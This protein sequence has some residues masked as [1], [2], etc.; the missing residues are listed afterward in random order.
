MA[1]L[2]EALRELDPE[3]DRGR[4]AGAAGAPARMMWALNRGAEAVEIAERALAMLPADDPER[5]AAAAAG[6]A[7]AQPVPARPVPRAVADGEAALETAV[8]AGDARRRGRGAQHA[9]AWPG[10]RSATSTAASSR[11]AA[12]ADR[13]ASNE[14][15]DSLATAYSN[16][17]DMLSVAGRTAEALETAREGLAATPRHHARSHD[18]MK[19]TVAEHGLRGRRL[20]AGP[21]AISPAAVA[22]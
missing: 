5:R 20:G 12:P 6:L 1:L 2:S 15:F 13:P 7:G 18:W 3:R 10:S 4:Y 11:C 22:G 21:G 14:D 9:R 17:A 16:L 19:L 8:A